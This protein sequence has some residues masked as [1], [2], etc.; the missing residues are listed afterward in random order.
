MERWLNEKLP[1]DFAI[2]KDI[3]GG[4]NMNF[5]ISGTTEQEVKIK[6]MALKRML[7]N[8]RNKDMCDRNCDI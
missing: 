4:G 2:I 6:S 7:K 1:V 8:M 3:D 5:H